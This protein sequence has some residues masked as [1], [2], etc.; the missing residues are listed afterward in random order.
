MWSDLSAQWKTVFD[1]AWRAFCFGSTPIGAALFDKSGKLI[2]SDR[3]RSREADEIQR[4]KY[5][6]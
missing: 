1:E 4:L 2:L 3:N 6:K 5:H